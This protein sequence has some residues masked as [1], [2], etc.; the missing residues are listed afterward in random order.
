M[1]KILLIL[2]LIVIAAC[3][4]SKNDLP[5]KDENF[6]SAESL[7]GKEIE[8]DAEFFSEVE[9]MPSVIGGMM[10]IQKNI[11]YPKEAKEKGISGRVL[12]RAYIDEKGNVEKTKIVRGIGFGCDEAAAI[13]IRKTKFNPGINKG[14][15]VKVA[16]AIPI[17]FR[18]DDLGYEKNGTYSILGVKEYNRNNAS[19][20]MG[21]I[22]AAKN[23]IPIIAANI[24][25]ENTDK[26]A[27]TDLGGNYQINGIKP[28][29]YKFKVNAKEFENFI[30]GSIEIKENTITYLDIKLGYK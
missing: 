24:L 2:L 9:E 1:K 23:D 17:V 4:K 20:L 26:G 13:A 30:S 16:C 8:G 6:T 25:L 27:A 10:E 28:G 11:V 5:G 19:L 14:K 21:R 3:D 22:T 18:L 15:P 29:T 7:V 12:I